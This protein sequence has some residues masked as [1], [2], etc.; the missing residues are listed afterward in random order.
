[1]FTISILVLLAIEGSLYYCPEELQTGKEVVEMIDNFNSHHEERCVNLGQ[2]GL[3]HIKD[4][5]YKYKNH[6][7]SICDYD[8]GYTLEFCGSYCSVEDC[9][10]T[11]NSET[12]IWDEAIIW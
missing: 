6:H 8:V 12:G 4:S 5:W 1:M 10:Y 11:Y 2:L 3:T 7:Y 9:Q